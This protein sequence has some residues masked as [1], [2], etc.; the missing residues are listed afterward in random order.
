MGTGTLTVIPL[1]ISGELSRQTVTYRLTVK[2]NHTLSTCLSPSSQERVVGY[3]FLG[4]SAGEVTQG[5]GLALRLGATKADFDATVG[6]HPTCA[7]NFTTMYTTKSSG[8]D[9][10]TSGC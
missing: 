6:I 10:A 8:V 5:F 2:T 3:H 4:P 7:E 1:P 9:V